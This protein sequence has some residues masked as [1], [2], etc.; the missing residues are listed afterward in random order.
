MGRGGRALEDR[1]ALQNLHLEGSLKINRPWNHAM[2]W[3]GKVPK[4]DRTKGPHNGLGWKGL[5]RSQKCGEGW[6]AL[7]AVG[8]YRM[9]T[10]KGL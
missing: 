8:L 10:Q 5:R 1:G 4:D 9:V 7:E 2:G 6:T 3:V